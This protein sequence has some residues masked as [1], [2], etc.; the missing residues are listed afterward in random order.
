[1]RNAD[2]SGRVSFAYFFDPSWDA[3]VRPLPV[4]RP[5]APAPSEPRCDGANVHELGGRYGDYLMAKV[6]K[7]FP[8]LGGQVLDP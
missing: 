2:R 5:P 3:E 7:V 8:D 1:V 6:A 4:D